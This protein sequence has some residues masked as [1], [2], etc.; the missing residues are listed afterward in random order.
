MGVVKPGNSQCTIKS[1]SEYNHV[2]FQ[3]I[4]HCLIVLF[5]HVHAVPIYCISTANWMVLV[6]VG[7]KGA[8]SFA[9]LCSCGNKEE[10]SI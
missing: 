9:K 5:L 3:V 7:E 2:H 10:V 8:G 6:V 4:Q 1:V